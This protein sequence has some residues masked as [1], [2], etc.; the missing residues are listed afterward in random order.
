M[1]SKKNEIECGP[2][3]RLP[4]I[5]KIQN[6]YQQNENS[7]TAENQ[8]TQPQVYRTLYEEKRA[9]L[10][11]KEQAKKCKPLLALA[12]GLLL[13]R[14][15]RCPICSPCNKVKDKV[16]GKNYFKIPFTNLKVPRLDHIF[17][18]THTFDQNRRSG[19]KCG[20]C[21]GKKNI[22]D[23]TDDSLKYQNLDL[24]D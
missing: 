22:P 12:A 20:I 10:K 17:D 7:F 21:G 5:Q 2:I 11:K 15:C 24:L 8:Q 6:E 4:A 3:K 18:K 19:Q 9:I 16:G 23:V 1:D 13:Q 14:L